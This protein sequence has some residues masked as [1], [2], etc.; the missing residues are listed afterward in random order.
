MRPHVVL[1]AGL[2][3]ACAG[4]ASP[5]ASAVAGPSG[6][7]V[8]TRGDDLYVTTAD[9]RSVRLLT[10]AARQAAVSADGRRIAF[11]R[12]GSIWV[13]GRDASRQKRITFSHRD[14]TPAW[15]PD[16]RTIYFS[17]EVEGKDDLGG[18]EFAWPLFRMSH[19]GSR[20]R[21]VTR[22]PASSHGVCDESPSVSPDGRIVAYASIAECDRGS[23]PSIEAV[24]RAGKPVALAGYDL[25]TAGFDPAWS[26]AGRVLAFASVDEYGAPNGI[27]TASPGSRARRMYRRTASDP[28]WSPDGLW[29]AFV[30]GV[31]RGRI[32][33][34]G[35]DGTGLRRLSSR[36]YDAD[37]VWL[38]AVP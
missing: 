27:V 38:P 6:Q 24:D 22:P 1:A 23:D 33:L 32:W 13:M 31:G 28:A 17:R 35:Q 4:A 36:R 3:L 34:V 30:R 16:G 11:V 7:I 18:Y 2:A 10:R 8:F 37:P 5:G 20:I 25:R 15:A 9:G 14:S 26:P 12:D 29:M 21:Q 19:E